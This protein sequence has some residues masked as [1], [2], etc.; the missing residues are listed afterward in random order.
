[1]LVMA[2]FL[3]AAAQQAGSICSTLSCPKCE[4]ICRDTCDVDYKK[5]YATSNRNCQGMYRSCERGC[6]AQLCAQCLPVQYG[7]NDRKF[8]PGKTE[9][10]QTPGRSE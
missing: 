2:G 6:K 9:L 3:P 5:C 10:C 4:K 1:M 8:L 7:S